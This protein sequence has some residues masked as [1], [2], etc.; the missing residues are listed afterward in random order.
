MGIDIVGKAAVAAGAGQRIMPSQYYAI[1]FSGSGLSGT[2]LP[3][4]SRADSGI[5]WAVYSAR[6]L[7]L[8]LYGKY[9]Y[10]RDC[11]IRLMSLLHFFSE[12]SCL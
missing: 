12:N 4:L 10:A 8:R 6:A 5:F 3:T 11:A 2:D 1:R 9:R 7:I